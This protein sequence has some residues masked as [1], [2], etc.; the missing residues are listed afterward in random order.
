MKVSSQGLFVDPLNH[1]YHNILNQRLESNSDVL[2]ALGFSDYSGMPDHLR[3]AALERGTAVHAATAMLDRR[4]NWRRKF[5]QFEGWVSAWMLFKKD[6]QFKP[7]LIEEPLHDPVLMIATTPDRWGMSNR[8]Y[9]TV[10]I[11]TGKVQAWVGLQTAFEER[12]VAISQGFEPPKTSSNRRFAIEL[13]PDG[14]Y[15]PERFEE[16]SDIQVYCGAVSWM[17]WMRNHNGKNSVAKYLSRNG[18]GS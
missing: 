14:T 11:K 5:K 9:I 8:G 16:Q 7:E 15:K 17:R 13:R 10:Q 12:C 1:T 2:S 6:F 18:G 3:Q 4:Q